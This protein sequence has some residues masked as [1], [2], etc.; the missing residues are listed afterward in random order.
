MNHNTNNLRQRVSIFMIPKM[1]LVGIMMAVSSVTFSQTTPASN[2]PSFA[3]MTIE[4]SVTI[5]SGLHEVYKISM[6]H[7]AFASTLEAKAYFEA[8]EVDFMTFEVADANTVFLKFD[9]KNSAVAN[10]TISEWMTAL[11]KRAG[12]FPPRT[13]P[14][15]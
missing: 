4:N 14:S 9:L 1:L 10:W 13:L 6:N 5:R 12:K 2:G 15:N 7:F 8:R 11:D 3:R